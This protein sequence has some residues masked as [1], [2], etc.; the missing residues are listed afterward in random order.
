MRGIILDTSTERGVVAIVNEGSILFQVHL[1]Q[2]LQTA[3]SLLPKLQEELHRLNI[4]LHT[5]S[6]VAVGVGPGSYTGI[7]VAATIAKTLAFACKLPLIGICTL[8]A[9]VP[10]EEGPFA[11]VID[12]KIGG[13]Y[14]QK[15]ILTAGKILITT[16][17]GVFPLTEAIQLLQDI[18]LIV[19]PNAEKIRP[20]LEVLSP[21]SHWKWEESYP[22]CKQF[23]DLAEEKM[24]TGSIS[25][26]LTLLYMRKT[27][28]EIEREKKAKDS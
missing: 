22:S 16:P 19:T 2:G 17:P 20:K 5:L 9:F 12:A 15:G 13:V 11:V 26:D 27:Q 25:A 7:R 8:D 23:A 1:P 6:Y 18:P 14:L 21:A 28:A 10:T 4:D 3:Q 24:R